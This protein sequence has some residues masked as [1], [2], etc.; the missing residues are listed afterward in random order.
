M[1]DPGKRDVQEETSAKIK[2]HQ[3]NKDPVLKEA[4]TSEEGDEIQ[5]DFQGTP[6]AENE[7]RGY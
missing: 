7:K 1:R 2:G 6:R 3:W 4:T 5:Q